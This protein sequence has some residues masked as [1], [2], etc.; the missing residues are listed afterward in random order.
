MAKAKITPKKKTVGRPPKNDPDEVAEI[1]AKIDEY[2]KSLRDGEEDDPPTFSGLSLA[3]GYS[4]R[5]SLW[6]NANAKKLIS[7]PIKKAMLRIESFAETKAYG[8]NAAGPIFILKNRGWT[9]KQEIEHSG[10]VTIIDDVK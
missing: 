3:L 2:F 6:E 8:N 9:D 5:T 1:Q 7:E 4:S 10:A